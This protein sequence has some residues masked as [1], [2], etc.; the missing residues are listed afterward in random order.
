MYSLLQQTIAH[1]GLK[2]CCSGR[3]HQ[4][5][6]CKHPRDLGL[7]K[8]EVSEANGSLSEETVL[9]ARKKK[10]LEQGAVLIVH[11]PPVLNN[12]FL[13]ISAKY[14]IFGMK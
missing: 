4:N 1:G 12:I 5:A 6:C 3:K 8:G 9:P 13:P 2:P 7:P 14:A 11:R 10:V